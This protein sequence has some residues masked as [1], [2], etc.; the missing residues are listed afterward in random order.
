MS[1]TDQEVKSI[2]WSSDLNVIFVFRCEG[3]MP[4]ACLDRYQ[5]VIPK[6]IVL[7]IIK[8]L[9]QCY[10]CYY[11]MSL[12]ARGATSPIWMDSIAR[13]FRIRQLRLQGGIS[14]V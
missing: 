13:P 14:V 3:V 8:V 10:I 9:L 12:G 1:T 4:D 7:Q 11:Y 5:V 6:L 2:Y